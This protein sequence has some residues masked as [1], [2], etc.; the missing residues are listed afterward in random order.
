MGRRGAHRGL[1]ALVAVLGAAGC[2]PAAPVPG[3]PRGVLWI[4]LDTL[5]AD[6]LGCYGNARDTSPAID[7][8]AT[9]GAVFERAWSTTS[10]TLPAHL[11]MLTGLPISAHGACFS[12]YPGESPLRGEFVSE[13][14]ARAGWATGGFYAHNYLERPFFLDRGWDHWERIGRVWRESQAIRAAW[15]A[16]TAAGDRKEARRLRDA[17]GAMFEKGAPEADD[18]VDR[19]LAWLDGILADGSASAERGGPRP[20]LLFLH[21]FDVHTPYKP[22]GDFIER[23]DPH[24]DGPL[25]EVDV[26][27]PNRP[28]HPGMDPRDLERVL[29]LYD[30]EVAWVDSQIGRLLDAFEERGLSQDTLVLLTSDHGDEFLEH[31]GSGHHHTLY[32]ELVHVPMVLR[33]PGRIP[34]ET[35]VAARTSIVDLAPTV[36]AACGVAPALELPGLD[37]IELARGARAPERVILSELRLYDDRPTEWQVSLVRDDVQYVVSWPGTERASV[38]RLDLARGPAAPAEPLAWESAEGRW[39]RGELD[40]QRHRL[41]ELRARAPARGGALRHLSELDQA[42]LSA[43]GYAEVDVGLGAEDGGADAPLCMDGC[44]WPDR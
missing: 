14:L 9:E 5:R 13:A 3:P 28:V 4:S 30:A 26:D 23:F 42:E 20:F 12:D 43:L 37:L 44:I 11:S 22:P 21:V 32:P 18:A 19:A 33:W 38:A 8:L 29:A 1:A 2:G 31:G 16:A 27:D 24:Y 40:R 6:R 15:E 41:A 39:V 25:T 35:R 10:W 17:H 34:A 36:L 7:R